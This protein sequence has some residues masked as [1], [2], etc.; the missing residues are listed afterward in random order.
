MSVQERNSTSSPP[1]P[2]QGAHELRRDVGFVGATAIVVGSI[3]GSGIFLVPHDM[4]QLVGSVEALLLAWIVAGLLATAGSLSLAELGAADPSAGGIYVYLR[5]AY[6]KLVAFVYGWALLLVINSGGIAILAVGFGI[7]I[8]TLV[9][10]SPL[11]RKFV[12][13]GLIGLLTMV[14]IL[15]VRKGAAVQTLF[16][17]A[18]L[19][20]LLIIIGAAFFTRHVLPVHATQPLPTPNTTVGSFGIA[21]IG[22]IWA[23]DGWHILSFVSGEVKNPSRV[24]PLSYLVGIAVVMAVYLA[25]NFAYL[26]VVPLPALAEHQRV[27][28]RTMEVLAGVRGARFVTVLILCSMFG[29]MNGIVLGAPRVYYAMARDGL[30]FSS[31]GRVHPRYATPAVA[32]LIQGGWAILLAASGTYKQLYTYVISTGWLFYGAAT[33][34]VLVLRHKHPEI[35]RPYRVWGYPVLPIVFSVSA[36]LIVTNALLRSPRETGIGLILALV[37]IPIFLIWRRKAAGSGK[38]ETGN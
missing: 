38:V 27:A 33:I 14:N 13:G 10:L 6:G 4:A 19:A 11:E 9:P 30:F 15:G 18:K 16:T 31:V 24:L 34:A 35:P 7:Y 36:L 3:I 1:A 21:L 28:A 29:A 8:T 17:V 32:L 12:A 5:E 23:Y 22:A 25:V 2:S 37:G 20:G 26:R